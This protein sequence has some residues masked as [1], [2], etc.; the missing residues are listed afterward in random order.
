VMSVLRTFPAE[1]ALSRSHASTLIENADRQQVFPASLKTVFFSS[2]V[3]TGLL[4]P[5]AWKRY[6][7]LLPPRC[8]RA[9]HHAQPDRYE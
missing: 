4:H 1:K 6:F 7:Y 2:S 9:R 3:P 5:R 8:L